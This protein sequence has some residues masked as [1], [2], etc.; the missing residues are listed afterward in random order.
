[1][2]LTLFETTVHRSCAN[3]LR[4]GRSRI[5]IPAGA[6]DFSR[7]QNV[8]T[9]YGVIQPPIEYRAVTALW[10]TWLRREANRLST[11]N[12]G[13]Q[14][15]GSYIYLPP[16]P[17]WRAKKILHLSHLMYL[18]S[19]TFQLAITQN[20]LLFDCACFPRILTY[21]MVQSPS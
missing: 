13:V 1:M 4:A 11:P 21:S 12:A 5:P 17:L 2:L 9:S 18:H 19:R 14:N 20:V 16:T 3:R 15:E 8:P 6:R 10:V 7:L